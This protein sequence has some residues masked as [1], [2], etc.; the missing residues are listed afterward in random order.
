LDSSTAQALLGM[1]KKFG[2]SEPEVEQN[3]CGKNNVVGATTQRLKVELA[4][5]TI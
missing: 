2:A 5:V 4:K 1:Y 3:V